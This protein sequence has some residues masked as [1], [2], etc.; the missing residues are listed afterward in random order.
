[1]LV[2]LLKV[3]VPPV[4]VAIMSLAARRWGP[5]IGGLLLGIPWMT[6]PV[7]A[8]LSLDKGV[9][10]A[11]GACV[12]IE[13][14]VVCISAFML[15]YGLATAI[16]PWPVCLAGAIAAFAAVAWAFQGVELALIPAA[17]AGAAS[18]VVAYLLMPKPT[19]SAFP[20]ALPWWD[21]PMRM[22]ATFVL[23][24]IIML[25]ADF[26]GPR[27][28]GIVSTYPAMLT[29]I[30]TFTHHQWGRDPVRR[31]LRGLTLSLFGFVAFFVVVGFGLPVLGLAISYAIAATVAVSIS[32]ALMGLGLR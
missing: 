1:M 8:F 17:V 25:S 28:S 21:I 2:F 31:V 20:A 13:L 6:G 26:M 7:L 22:L 27:L 32:L 24:A 10:F 16:A 29:V 18:L 9:P 11:V 12:G 3:A 14:G 15:V 5:T 30:G 23:V 4:L 19:T